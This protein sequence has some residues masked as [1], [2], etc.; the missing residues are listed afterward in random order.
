MADDPKKRGQDSKLV[1]QQQHEVDYLVK[2][3]GKPRAEVERAIKEVGPSR[4]K[5]LKK[6]QGR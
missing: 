3:T 1:S 4:E 2:T 6:L 5:V